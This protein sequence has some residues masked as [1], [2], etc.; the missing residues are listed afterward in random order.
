MRRVKELLLNCYAHPQRGRKMKNVL[1]GAV[2]LTQIQ[3][4][5]ADSQRFQ[6]S[7]GEVI[8]KVE[9]QSDYLFVYSENVDVSKTL[10]FSSGNITVDEYIAAIKKDSNYLVSVENNYV[11]IKN[12]QKDLQQNQRQEKIIKGTVYDE[13]GEVVIGANILVVGT[14]NGSVT[15]FDGNFSLKMPENAQVKVSYIGYQ[16]QI[17]S[18]K[19]KKDLKITLSPD[20]K[21]LGEVVVTALGIKREEKALGYAVQKVSGGTLD[22][23]KGVD[24]AT[25]LTGKVA[26]L[27]VKNSTEFAAAP[28]IQIRGEKP[29][30]VID[31]VPYE[32]LTLRDVPS[33]DI[34]DISVLKGATASALYGHRGGSGAVM[35]T[36]KKGS[37]KGFSV[38]FNSSTMFTAGYLA[39][40]ETQ[41]TFGR[42]LNTATNT[43]SG[44]GDGSWGIPMDGREV[45]QWDPVSKTMKLMPYLPHGKNNFKNFLEQGYILNNNIAIANQGKNGG[46][47]SSLTWVENKGQYPN[48]KFDKITYA[49]SGDIKLEKFTLTSNA[50]YNKQKTPN[51]GF[52]GY[53]AYDP[54]YSLLI[55]GANDFNVLDYQDYWVVPNEVQNNSYTAGNNNPY[56]DRYERTHSMDRDVFNMS[57]NL[58]YDLPWVKLAFRTGFDTFSDKQEVKVSKGSF[59]GAGATTVIPGG[60]EVWGESQRGSYNQGISRGFSI[61]N[62]FIATA[63]QKWKDFRLEEMIG[64]SVSFKQNEGI[65]ARTRGGLSI[66][67]FYSIKASIEQAL[68]ASNIYRQQVN[69]VYGRFG[70]S[71]KSMLYGEATFRNDWSSTLSENT[72]SYL[73]PSFSGSFIASEVLPEYDWLS[74]WKLRGSWTSSKTPAGIYSIN[75]VYSIANNAWGNLG[76]AQLPSSIRGVEVRPESASTFE[77][78]T[79]A[80]FLNNRISVD[81]SMYS[82]RMYDFLRSTGISSASGYS[83]KFVN[84]D[85]EITRRGIELS[86]NVTP[87][88]SKDW[89]VD[90]G[91]NWSKYARYY[92]QLDDQFSAD[93]PWVKVGERVDHF[94]LRDYQRDPEGNIIH[95]NGLPQYSKY[96][97]RYGYADPDW[98]WGGNIAVK[99]KNW[100]LNVALD[101][102]VGGLTSS[103][104]EMYMWRSGGHPNSVNDARYK[105]VINPGSKNYVGSGVKVI[106]GSA[107]YD[108]YGNIL[109]D[110]RVYAA[111]DIAT[112]YKSYIEN[113]HK[114]NAWGGAPSVVDAY[115]TTFFKIRELSLTYT[116]P[117]EIAGKIKSTGISASFV[118]QNLFLW[119]KQF[120]YSDPDGGTDN[121]SDPSQ[122]YLGFNV[123]VGF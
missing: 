107:T 37:G 84:I 116:L 118:A 108:T 68:V 30:I 11:V 82:K 49:I 64:G 18:I 70:I 55:W 57:L 53:T 47:R 28:D 71:W 33:D 16:P 63:D 43:I 97:S 89:R 78:G 85:E 32:N 98:I 62:D 103:T 29:L 92:T 76:S 61:S 1:L 74:I 2:L 69:S 119:A 80:N 42:V 44:S 9:S 88:Q 13:N 38:T 22:N 14:T 34:E 46:F 109:T 48:S 73:Y 115:S 75:Q 52:N 20:T 100:Q 8:K 83:S 12:T 77:I 122:R 4:V 25:S 41:S 31:G 117:S 27:M 5:F 54:M 23:V 113:Y 17:I 39:I 21:N 56:F 95:D 59:Q 51:K 36:T 65:E 86:T 79:M 19:G 112:T 99:Y 123:K 50:S 105:D 58:S 90:V 120:K 106:S 60:S 10:L 101:G 94:I 121:F 91:F 87:Y 6:L 45:N 35:I 96:D 66:P 102:R 67:G 3:P 104:T 110:N 24:V 111:N 40:P 7:L 72:R 81:V 93:K 15:D 26:G 114:G